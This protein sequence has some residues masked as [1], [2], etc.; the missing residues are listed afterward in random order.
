MKEKGIPLIE[1]ERTCHVVG[2]WQKTKTI[3]NLNVL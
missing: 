3:M 1:L 2:S